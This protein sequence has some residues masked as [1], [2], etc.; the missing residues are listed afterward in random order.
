MTS[1]WENNLPGIDADGLATRGFTADQLSAL[2]RSLPVAAAAIKQEAGTR[3]LVIASDA[4]KE[5]GLRSS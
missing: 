2:A 1:R 4:M 3:E 5:R